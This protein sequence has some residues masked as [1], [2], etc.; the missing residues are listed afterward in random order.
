M[1]P[2]Q[3]YHHFKS[4]SLVQNSDFVMPASAESSN[5]KAGKQGQ[6]G[7]AYLLTQASQ[8]KV[9]NK[10]QKPSSIAPVGYKDQLDLGSSGGHSKQKKGGG[11]GSAGH[12]IVNSHVENHAVGGTAQI[13]DTAANIVKIKGKHISSSFDN[14]AAGNTSKHPLQPQGPPQQVHTQQYPFAKMQ[15]QVLKQQSFQ[16]N[17][18]GQQPGKALG[19]KIQ[20]STG[21]VSLT[22]GAG[23]I[24]MEG[25]EQAVLEGTV[26]PQGLIS[27]APILITHGGGMGGVMNKFQKKGVNKAR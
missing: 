26:G 21:M 23:G 12:S 10:Q 27:G 17:S 8:P 5:V 3:L 7:G 24:A 6:S 13:K 20:P 1:Q 22:T 9:M 11:H 19:G 2:T 14:T 18:Q 4:K 16:N 15:R 25:Q